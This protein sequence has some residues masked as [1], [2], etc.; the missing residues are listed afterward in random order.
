MAGILGRETSASHR[1]KV[2]TNL[3]MLMTSFDLS[4]H[5]ITAKTILRNVAP[6][7]LYEEA[8]RYEPGTTISDTGALIAYSG[9]K[10]GRSPQDKR[11]V[12]HPDSEENIW[13]GPVN[14]PLDQVSFSINRERAKDYLNTRDRL[15]VVDGY[16]GW[17]PHHLFAAVSRVVHAPDA[18]SPHRRTAEDLPRS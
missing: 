11:L 4:M 10:T 7:K 15:Y 13:W 9:D 5:G 12:K 8:I 16:A 2:L 1:K 3:E 6:S 14:F 17:D 18:D